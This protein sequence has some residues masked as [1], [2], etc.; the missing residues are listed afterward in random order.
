MKNK[1]IL[2]SLLIIFSENWA[3]WIISEILAIVNK[4]FLN[5]SWDSLAFVSG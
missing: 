2:L 3:Q 4:K 5:V 1:E